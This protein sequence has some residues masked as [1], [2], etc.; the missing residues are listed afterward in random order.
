MVGA[1]GYQPAHAVG[2]DREFLDPIRPSLEKNLEHAGKA[3]PVGGHV[4]T[5][6]VV[7]I[8]GRVAQGSGEDRTVVV[9]L[10]VPLQIIQA[11]AV[12][13]HGQFAASLR[14]R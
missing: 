4:Q 1:P 11:K 9:P 8:D 12:R 6:V 2:D 10:A 3:A 13:Q 7:E 5:A 14:D